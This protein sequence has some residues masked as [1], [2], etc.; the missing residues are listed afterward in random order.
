MA[1]KKPPTPKLP[2]PWDRIS[3][4][5]GD[6]SAE[7]TYAAVGRALSSW[8]YFENEFAKLFSRFLGLLDNNL[9]A[10]RAYGSVLTFKGRASMVEAAAEAFYFLKPNP[11]MHAKIEDIIDRS[12]QFSGRR[13]EIAHGVVRQITDPGPVIQGPTG[14]MMRLPIVWGYGVVPS[15][16][17]TNKTDLAPALSLLSDIE[18][19]PKYR[20]SSA[21]LIRYSTE[22]TILG[23]ETQILS[24]EIFHRDLR[25]ETSL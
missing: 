10:I 15:E 16:Y 20:Y 1:S 14:G 9:P 6:D 24:T 11:T 12:G 2:Q 17:A 18:R 23:S 21:E 3:G 5:K 25:G 22:F 4:L 19:V 7:V 13:N 8:E